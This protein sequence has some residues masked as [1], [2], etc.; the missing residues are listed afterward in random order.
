MLPSSPS[1]RA[2]PER[3]VFCL[4]AT[5][6]AALAGDLPIE[7]WGSSRASQ[8]ERSY[9]WRK[10]PWLGNCRLRFSQARPPPGVCASKPRLRPGG[11]GPSRQGVIRGI[12][13]T[14]GSDDVLRQ[15]G[16]TDAQTLA[17]L[18]DAFTITVNKRGA[19]LLA[20]RCVGR[21]RLRRDVPDHDLPAFP[22]RKLSLRAAH[23]DVLQISGHERT[24]A[25]RSAIG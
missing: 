24:A 21:A 19:D 1:L 4:S 17:Q 8:G 23:C 15:G 7:A 5:S 18:G 22:S 13:G 2:P 14:T 11:F 6:A 16:V 25:P 20:S 3:A 9:G 10:K 12:S